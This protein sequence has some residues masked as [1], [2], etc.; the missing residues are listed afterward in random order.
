MKLQAV[1]QPTSMLLPDIKA[2]AK[3]LWLP[4]GGIKAE[5][6]MRVL[7]FFQLRVPCN[8]PALVLMAVK[9]EKSDAAPAELVSAVHQLKL[10]PGSGYQMWRHSFGDSHHLHAF[11]I[12]K[13]LLDSCGST[14]AVTAVQ[15]QAKISSMQTKADLEVAKHVRQVLTIAVDCASERTRRLQKAADYLK[16]QK[17]QTAG[18]A[19]PSVPGMRS[20]NSRQGSAYGKCELCG[21]YHV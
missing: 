10:S 5:V 1:R 17:A 8:V 12:R 7:D 6:V 11:Y 18:A 21:D 14:A 9:Q 2:A 4:V 15:E 16:Q 3:Q 13:K 20:D 19:N